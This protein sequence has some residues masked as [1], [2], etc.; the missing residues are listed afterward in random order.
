[1]KEWYVLSLS[2]LDDVVYLP[3]SDRLSARFHTYCVI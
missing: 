2:E 1:M 3:G